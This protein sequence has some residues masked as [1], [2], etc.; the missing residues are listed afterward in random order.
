MATLQ[1]TEQVNTTARSVETPA[2]LVV[3]AHPDDESFGMGGTLV[4]YARLG[5]EVSLVCA[6]RGEVGD[7]EPEMLAGHAS[8]AELREGEL[9]CAAGLLGLKEVHFLGYRDSGMPGSPENQNPRALVAQPLELVADEVAHFI[10]RVRPQVVITFDPIGGYRH[11][12]HI[13][14]HRATV[15]AFSLASDSTF[16]DPDGLPPYAPQR[17][18]FNTFSRSFLRFVVWLLRVLGQDPRR[19]GRNHDIDLT[20]LTIED[21]PIHAEV[22]FSPVSKIRD[23]AAACH[24][25]QG[26]KDMFRGFR[27]LVFKL[28]RRKE[29]Y[30]QAYPVPETSRGRISDLFVGVEFSGSAGAD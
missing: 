8:I 20:L 15:R 23:Q 27:G 16:I 12:D 11:P 28:F 19:Y 10:R 1:L 3:L 6:T 18:F 24:A 29:T 25:S 4:R 14:I 26:G 30:M 21:F 5:V 9:R 17:L 2:L 7:V 22:D 13:F